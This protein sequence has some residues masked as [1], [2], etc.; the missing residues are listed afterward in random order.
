[1]E[2]DN[3]DPV[4]LQKR[5]EALI[6]KITA[7]EELIWKKNMLNNVEFPKKIHPNTKK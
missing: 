3:T 5:F 4:Q 1:M 6:K 7:L 2:N